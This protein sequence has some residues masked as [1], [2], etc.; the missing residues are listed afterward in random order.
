MR[1]ARL[2]AV[3]VFV[4][5]GLALFTLGL[6]L[7]GSRRMLFEDR[8][9]VYT[10]MR[11]I[12]GLQDGAKVRVAGMDAGEV[13][14]ILPPAGPSAPFR[15]KLRIV[16]RLHPLV[17][18]DSVAMVQTDG[19]V[20]DKFVAVGAGTDRAPQVAKDGTIP[21]REPFELVDLLQQASDTVRTI[22]DT[23]TDLKD[24]VEK[25]VTVFAETAE[26]ADALIEETG[27]DVK[28]ITR[29][30]AQVVADAREISESIRTGRGTIG[31][32]VNDDELYNR[33]RQISVDAERAI[34]N[35]REASE[36]ARRAMTDFRSKDGP[37]Q[38]VA[39]DLRQTLANAREA[40]ADLA[41]NTEALK[42]NWFFRGFFNRRGFFDLSG[43][44]VEEYRAGALAT[45]GR[46]PIRTWLGASTLFGVAA[47]GAESLTDAGRTRLN[48]AMADVLRYP[49][50]SPLIVEGYATDPT[51]D[52]AFL[53]SR[54]RAALVR[55]YLV[56]TFHLDPA[57][58]GLMAL[59]DGAVGSPAGNRWDGVALA[60][61]TDASPKP[62]KAAQANGSR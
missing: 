31:K 2:I 8:F 5:G 33:A 62:A 14:D 25:A 23:V 55:E 36:E 4:I 49:A 26:H 21:G 45:K 42:R 58:V 17:R 18:T 52:Q 12:S 24:D 13:V 28:A 41:E 48:A 47:D 29:S 20:G 10:E 50:N 3:G 53:A 15:I 60:L 35:V 1:Q 54:A 57:Y 43:L 16:E 27:A 11:R 37:V 32:L 46:R 30:G 56:Q 34:Q 22:D 19:L 40:M 38:G 9:D 44:T 7:I 6:F 59:V 61:F 39:S 51:L